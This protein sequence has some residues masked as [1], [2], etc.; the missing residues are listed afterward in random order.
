MDR[1]KLRSCVETV[2][3]KS[4]KRTGAFTGSSGPV[5]GYN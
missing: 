2:S 3:E 1:G 4:F 5:I